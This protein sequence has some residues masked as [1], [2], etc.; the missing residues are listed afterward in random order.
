MNN[1]NLRNTTQFNNMS[2][3]GFGNE[4]KKTIQN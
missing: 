2:K 4:D 1:P 3:Y